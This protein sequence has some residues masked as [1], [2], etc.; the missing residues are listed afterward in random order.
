MKKDVEAFRIFVQKHPKLIREVRSNTR[1]WRDVYEDWVVLG[2]HHDIWNEYK[3]KQ[4]SQEE[5]THFRGLKERKQKQE[6]DASETKKEITVGD[7]FSMFRDINVSE[8]GQHLAQFSGAIEGIHQLLKQ[9]QG[10]KTYDSPSSTSK[11][12]YFSSYKD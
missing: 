5:Y 2:E 12:N 3:P 1:S 11:D 7:L 10:S 9:F 6:P 8:I 4:K